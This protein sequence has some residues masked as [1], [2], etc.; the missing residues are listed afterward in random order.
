MTRAITVV[1]PV[2]NGE[3]SLQ[4]L[5]R[6]LTEVLSAIGTSYEMIFVNDCSRDRSWDVISQLAVTVP[7]VRG[8]NLMRNYGQHNALLCG[9]RAAL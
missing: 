1:V 5:C 4:E 7:G 3:T 9:I 6:R 2:Y 8:I